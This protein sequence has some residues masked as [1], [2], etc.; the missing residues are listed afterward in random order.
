MI[1]CT[2]CGNLNLD[3]SISCDHCRVQLPGA[4]A[5][6]LDKGEE[7]KARAGLC[8]Q[9]S[10]A[11]PPLENQG[12][13]D[14]ST[15]PGSQS[16]RSG[17]EASAGETSEI[18]RPAQNPFSALH[19]AGKKKVHAKLTITRG[20]SVGTEFSL[21]EKESIIGRWDADNGVF[22]DLDLERHD[23]E[24]KISRR[25]A[26]IILDGDKH[27]VEDLGSTNGTFINRGRRLIPG[28]RHP[29]H[30]GD[31]LILGKTFLKF[32]IEK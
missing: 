10:V 29:L 4:S 18:I 32:V 24:C 17:A 27:S 28:S 23:A 7:T 25:H 5:V 1:R 3:R 22:P 15:D 16:P 11:L 19:K 6:A 20:S 26:K 8:D 12:S 21:T 9:D 13:L 2:N 14:Q 31:E 30:N